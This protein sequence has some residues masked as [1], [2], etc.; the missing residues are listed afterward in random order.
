MKILALALASV[1]MASLPL[2][3]D[4]GGLLIF[5]FNCA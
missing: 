2:G 4:E 3:G 1:R 5:L